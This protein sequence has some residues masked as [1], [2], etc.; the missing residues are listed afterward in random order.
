M[1]LREFSTLVATQRRMFRPRDLRDHNV[2]GKF[3]SQTDVRTI[4]AASPSFCASHGYAPVRPVIGHFD[5][6]S[7]ARRF[8][9][10]KTAPR[11]ERARS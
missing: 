9:A 3:H 8:N 4:S 1:T 2:E 10:P 6:E 5:E 11:T 7:S